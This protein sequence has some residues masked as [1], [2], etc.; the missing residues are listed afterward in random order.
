MTT[1]DEIMARIEADFL[2]EGRA[3]GRAEGQRDLLRAMLVQRFGDLPH[4]VLERLFGASG[5]EVTRMASRFVTATTLDE[6][7][8]E[9]PATTI[10]RRLIEKGRSDGHVAGKRDL[11]RGMLVQRF[12]DLPHALSMRLSAAKLGDLDRWVH[13][14][15]T[16]T[17]IDGLFEDEE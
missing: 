11:M 16:A 4:S 10:G 17:T 12:G 13:R 2:A 5:D 6:I 9:E 15:H 7:V 14:F 3:K 1:A 8:P